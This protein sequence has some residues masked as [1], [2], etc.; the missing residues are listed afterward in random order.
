MDQRLSLVTVAV[1]SRDRSRDF[2]VAG[3][4]WEPHFD[5]VDVL[6]LRVGERVLLSLWEREAFEAEVGPI[7]TGVG[8]PPF[9]L[10]HNV[11]NDAEVDAVLEAA[12]AAGASVRGAQ[13]REWGGYSGYFA[14]PDGTLWEVACAPGDDL[15][16]LVP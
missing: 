10:A 3:L 7:A 1:S 8:H 14:D 13:R 9:T 6:M 5:G 2:Y 12:A 15:A 16:F 11:G 4:G